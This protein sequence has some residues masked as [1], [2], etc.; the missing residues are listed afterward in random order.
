VPLSG[1]E[2]AGVVVGAV[3]L[4]V[5]VW[6]IVGEW[7]RFTGRRD[8]LGRTSTSASADPPAPSTARAFRAPVP[9]S[10]RLVLT[11]ARGDCWLVVRAGSAGGRVLFSG[12]LFRSRTVSFQGRK[13]W[14]SLGAASNV[15][16]RFN[17]KR[18]RGFPTGTANVLADGARTMLAN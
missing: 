11:A 14:I 8:G 18:L 13:F 6:L 5:L 9:T 3:V 15:D 16:A 1:L 7:D 10:G 4:G 12:T 2:R 17:G